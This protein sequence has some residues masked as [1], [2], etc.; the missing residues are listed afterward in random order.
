[1][2]LN[3]TEG[4]PFFL[5]EVLRSLLDAGIIVQEDGRWHTTRELTTLNIPD[6]V[7]EVLLARIDRLV[8]DMR[9]VL[10]MASVVGR[11]FLYR[12]LKYITEIGREL[13]AHL[14]QLQRVDLIRERTRIPELEYIFKHVLVQ[15]AA[16][17]TLLIERKKEIHRQVAECIE[18]FYTDRLEEYYGLI[19]HHCERA[20]IWSKAVEYLQKAGDK[21]VQQSANEEAIAHFSKGLELLKMLPDTLQRDQQEHGLRTSLYAPLV[22]T[23]RAT[24]IREMSDR[25]RDL[26]LQL[27]KTE[28][29]LQ[30][31]FGLW[32]SNV[33]QDEYHTAYELAEEYL[34]LAE[35]SGD[36]SMLM[37]SQRLMEESLFFLG[38]FSQARKHLEKGL[39][40]YSPQEHQSHAF[41]LGQDPRIAF[42]CYESWFLWLLGYPDQAMEKS[43]R[44]IKMAR[45]LAHPY[46][47]AL[48]LSWGVMLH[49]FRREAREAQELVEESISLSTEHSFAF[50]I[51]MGSVIRGW[52]LAEQ[53]HVEEGISQMRQGIDINQ[54]HGIK[55]WR[56]F[57]L[58][59]LAEVYGK[60]GKVRDGLNLLDEALAVM[61]VSKECWWEAEL[62]RLKGD[63]MLTQDEVGSD[64]EVWLQKAIQV[65]RQQ[66][67][68]SLELRGVVSLCRLLHKQDRREEARQA[69]AG[70]C[71]WFTEGFGTPD[72]REAEVLIKE[73]S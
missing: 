38:D 8:E 60:M 56:Q 31:L 49:C 11:T 36:S 59:L 21:A 57:S 66:K 42:L 24:D 19:A 13:D 39:A 68:K 20:E 12:I 62:Y 30:V 29:F 4:N 55:L 15:E 37:E 71:N 70:I 54:A 43:H 3:K 9:Q 52:A 33:T 28:Q 47:L 23:G 2:I 25:A 5:E 63:L 10:Q 16:Y 69:L 22:A 51:S 27:G 48:A 65:S 17:S 26:C 35:S 32:L 50:C 58:F 46:T 64:V 40:L 73:L 1:M 67:A 14:S 34:A 6:T 7:Q 61:E 44:A 41:R 72:L 18:I 45:E 53:G